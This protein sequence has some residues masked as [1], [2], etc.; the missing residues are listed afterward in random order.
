[1]HYDAWGNLTRR[2]S[3]LHEQ[4]YTYDAENRLVAARGTG[5]EGIFDA[6]YRY[7]ALGRRTRKTVTISRGTTDTRFLWQG[8][9]LLQEQHENGQCS[10]WIYDPNETWSPLARVDH[11]REDKA[12]EIYWFST[13]LNGAPLEVTD[14]EGKLRWS[15]QY[16]SFGEVRHQT[17]GF[18]RLAIST[19][20]LHQ[21]LRYAGQY[22]DSETGLHYNLFRYYD[23]QNG[24]FVVQDPIGLAGGINL[25]QYAP[26]T[27]LWVD[28]LGL[29][30]TGDYGKMPVMP[31]Y[32]KH[33]NIP[34]SMANHP[35]IVNS[36]YDVNN[37]RNIT[38]LPSSKAAIVADPGRTVHRGKHNKA[39]DD[40]VRGQL[41]AI[42]ASNASPEI[43]RLKIEA[44]SDDLG[45]K[46]RSKKIK[47]NNAC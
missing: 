11:L 35:A 25:Y 30:T 40:L 12:G 18:T 8:Y 46:L 39:Y 23:P 24:R 33:H 20:M 43:K 47:L 45:N 19:A 29:A 10:T 32:Q 41:D 21:P 17:D 36:G 3:G 37:S 27:L 16:G 4:H 28:P 7:D 15:G 22:A 2:R 44:L 34:Q 42:H 5:P 38:H 26:N 14:V 31:G 1:M 6:H 9:R 13:D